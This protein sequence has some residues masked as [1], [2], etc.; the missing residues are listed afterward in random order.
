M[1]PNNMFIEK[2][3]TPQWCDFTNIFDEKKLAALKKPKQIIKN[4]IKSY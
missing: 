1:C 2:T 4:N 3:S